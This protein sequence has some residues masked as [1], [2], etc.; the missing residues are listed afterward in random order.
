LAFALARRDL[1]AVLPALACLLVATTLTAALTAALGT[2]LLAGGSI[3][4]NGDDDIVQER[5]GRG[6]RKGAE[7]DDGRAGHGLDPRWTRPDS[8]W[9]WAQGIASKQAGTEQEQAERPT[10]FAQMLP[11]DAGQPPRFRHVSLPGGS[12]RG[13]RLT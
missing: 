8:E 11:A 6:E 10:L 1:T 7:S 13:P 3:L 9:A 5:D 2:A 4:R 12:R